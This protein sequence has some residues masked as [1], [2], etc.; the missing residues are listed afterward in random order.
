MGKPGLKPLI[1]P[2]KQGN[3]FTTSV[4]TLHNLVFF[5]NRRKVGN[6]L[7]SPNLGVGLLVVTWAIRQAHSS[8]NQKACHGHGMAAWEKSIIS[9]LSTEEPSCPLNSHLVPAGDQPSFR[10]GS[11]GDVLDHGAARNKSFKLTIFCYDG[12]DVHGTRAHDG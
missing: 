10:C 4:V 11:S 9:S 3:S 7:G 2:C 1:R 6:G 8:P 5:Y 12:H